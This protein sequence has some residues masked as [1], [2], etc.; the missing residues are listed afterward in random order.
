MQPWCLA[1]H[2]HNGSKSSQYSISPSPRELLPSELL[3]AL[4]G[5][6]WALL[7]N[8]KDCSAHVRS[9]SLY[10]CATAVSPKHAEPFYL[11]VCL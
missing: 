7:H 3:M 2:S 11:R 1:K 8:S 10:G 6:T 9:C 5:Q 4:R